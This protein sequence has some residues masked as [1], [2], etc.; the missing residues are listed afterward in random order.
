MQCWLLGGEVLGSKS[1]VGG[2]SRTFL[3]PA[4]LNMAERRGQGLV[5]GVGPWPITVPQPFGAGLARAGRARDDGKEEHLGEHLGEVW[6]G[7]EH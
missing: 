2:S 7:H 6:P 4:A 3:S 5:S 1:Q